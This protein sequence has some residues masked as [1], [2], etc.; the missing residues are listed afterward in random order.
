MGGS[1]GVAASISVVH[2]VLELREEGF[3]G[4]GRFVGG[5]ELDVVL[6]KLGRR[7]VAVRVQQVL[8]ELAC[9]DV[10]ESRVAMLEGADI[11]LVDGSD[12]LLFE[13]SIDMIVLSPEPKRLFVIADDALYLCSGAHIRY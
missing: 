8:D 12:E 10:G 1:V 13:S 4:L 7:D 11:E 3:N 2:G 6:G 5:S 9:G